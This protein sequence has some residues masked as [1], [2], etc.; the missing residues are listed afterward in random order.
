M[1]TQTAARGMLRG[2]EHIKVF[3]YGKLITQGHQEDLPQ[4]G[5][6]KG[7]EKEGRS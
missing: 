1:R 5:K 6:E 3:H 2:G 7:E 4:H